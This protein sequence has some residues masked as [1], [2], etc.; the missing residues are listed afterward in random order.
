MPN[1]LLTLSDYELPPFSRITW[2]QTEEAIDQIIIK[3]KNTLSK[4]LENPTWENLIWPFEIMQAQLE[5][6]VGVI[7]H[8]NAVMNTPEWYQ[9]YENTISKVSLYQTEIK[10]NKKFYQALLKISESEESLKLDL[11]AK[12]VIE[13]LLR[14]FRLSGIALPEDKQTLFKNLNVQLSKLE[15]QF[16]QNVL[17]ATQN[18]SLLITDLGRLTSLP[19]NA[20]ETA[21]LTAKQ[22]NKHGWLLTLDFPCYHAVMT[23]V[24]DRKIREEMYQA[25]NTRASAY[26]PGGKQWDNSPVMM[27]IMKIRQTLANLLDFNNYAEYALATRM[28][29]TTDEVMNFLSDLVTHSRKFAE[30]DLKTLKE[31]ALKEFQLNDIKV[32][33]VAYLSEKLLQKKYLITEKELQA[34]FPEEVVLQG[35]FNIATRLYGMVIQE[36]LDFDKWHDAVR[37]F[38]VYDSQNKLRGKFYIDLY[39][40]SNKQEGAWV[41]NC[42]VRIGREG[43]TFQVPVIY[44]IANFG[45]SSGATPTLLTH[46][47][48]I[49]LFHEFGHCLHF[50]LT[51]IDYPSITGGNGVYWDAIELPSQLMENWCWEEEALV[52]ISK[53]FETQLCLPKD[54]FLRLIATKNFQ[55][56]LKLIRQLEFGLF[57]FKLHMQPVGEEDTYIQNI[58]DDVRT[59]TALLPV[60]SFNQF[61]NSFSHIFSGRYAAGYYSYIWS[62]VLSSDVYEKFK[63]NNK[64]FD[65]EIA[66]KFLMAILEQGGSKDFMDLFINFQG[67]PPRIEALL[68]AYGF[69]LSSS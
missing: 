13:N 37:L 32:W 68:K 24:E 51:T 17:D 34:Y 39:T 53:H 41:A 67:R 59:K 4:A 46:D 22:Q 62:E 40:R 35:L 11:V 31:F 44:L 2:Q 36:V 63:S 45:K 3:S 28:L 54:L 14:D 23:Y 55:A 52:L 9:A 7:S 47:E 15:N 19:T 25:Y 33:D 20:L 16:K 65:Q 60:P 8:L 1:P 43:V 18:W 48:V 57:D 27:E 5:D 10:Q 21:H 49:T 38:E 6:I 61:Q 26:F 42:K 29:K 50:I 58:L 64:V 12:K 30:Q 56:G 66:Q 69:K